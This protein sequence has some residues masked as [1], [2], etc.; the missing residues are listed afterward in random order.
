[1]E[2]VHAYCA[3]CGGWVQLTPRTDGRGRVEWLVDRCRRCFEGF[4]AE[5]APF[6]WA[7]CPDCH[8]RRPKAQHGK[9]D[10][11]CARCAGVHRRA[12][13]RAYMLDYT[14]RDQEL[15]GEGD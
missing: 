1:M 13:M 11:R 9:L 2:R 15:N 8:K 12:Y 14:P 7:R 6:G 10:T 5:H 3:E 4:Q